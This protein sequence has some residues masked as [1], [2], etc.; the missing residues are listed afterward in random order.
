MNHGSL[1]AYGS[2]WAIPAL[3]ADAADRGDV[4]NADSHVCAPRGVRGTRSGEPIRLLLESLR[5]E[6]SALVSKASH[7]NA[8]PMSGL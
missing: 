3:V 2:W 8:S 4:P 5:V 7:P 1:Q 6:H